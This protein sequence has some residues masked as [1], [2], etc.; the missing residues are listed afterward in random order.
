[1]GADQA[2]ERIVLDFHGSFLYNIKYLVSNVRS[3]LIHGGSKAGPGSKA[4]HGDLDSDIGWRL[5][6]NKKKLLF[7][8]ILAGVVYFFLSYHVIFVGKTLKLLRK[9][10]H[11]FDYTFFSTQGKTSISILSIDD[12][13]RDG[14]GELL[15]EMGQLSEN[16][17]DMLIAQ[18]EEGRQD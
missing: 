12:L 11:T 8:A 7:W 5:M 18:I 1:M 17:L 10:R 3:K 16:Q 2:G 15:V 14:I 9:S 6:K 13:R 4:F